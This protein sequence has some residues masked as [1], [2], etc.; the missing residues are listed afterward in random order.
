MARVRGRRS[1]ATEADHG[2][3]DWS[4]P[5]TIVTGRYR[6]EVIHNPA[7]ALSFMA[8]RW[9]A[10]RD[11]DYH[12]ARHLASEFLRRRETGEAVRAA[13]LAAVSTV[14]RVAANSVSLDVPLRRDADQRSERDPVV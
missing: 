4:D 9:M 14:Y 13:F 6:Q 7:E 3:S 5:I 10:E 12:R 2:W 11:D 8:N 1:P